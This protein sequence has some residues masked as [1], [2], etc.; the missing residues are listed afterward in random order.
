MDGSTCDAL[1][2]GLLSPCRRRTL[3]QGA[4]GGALLVLL[5]GRGLEVEAARRGCKKKER[6]SPSTPCG[7]SDT[8]ECFVVAGLKRNTKRNKCFQSFDTCDRFLIC[9]SSKDCPAGTAC[10]ATCCDATMCVPLCGTPLLTGAAVQRSGSG[11]SPS[12]P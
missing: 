12:L 6:C 9:E 10:A 7:Q 11:G 2:K 3:L 8:C 5:P 1:T 4:L